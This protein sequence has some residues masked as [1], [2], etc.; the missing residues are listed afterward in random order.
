MGVRVAGRTVGARG[1]KLEVQRRARG[2]DDRQPGDALLLELRSIAAASCRF[3]PSALS[4][5]ARKPVTTM[6]A[7]SCS[8]G[9]SCAAA[10]P[11]IIMVEAMASADT[12][13]VKMARVT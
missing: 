5:D 1:S 3:M 12:R 9:W 10:D 6:S 4:S 2:S 8:A 7:V 11:A 13:R